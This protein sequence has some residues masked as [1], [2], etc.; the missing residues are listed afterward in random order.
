MVNLA[1][2]LEC[3][4]ANKEVLRCYCFPPLPNW[5]ILLFLARNSLRP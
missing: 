3:L 5:Y 1:S 4:L 2:I